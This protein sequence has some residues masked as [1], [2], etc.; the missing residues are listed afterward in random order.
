MQPYDE[1]LKA[2]DSIDYIAEKMRTKYAILPVHTPEEKDLFRRLLGANSNDRDFK[3]MAADWNMRYAN[4]KTV[5]YKL[6]CQLRR[7]YVTYRKIMNSVTTLQDSRPERSQ[8]S[9]EF[10]R[11]IV[12]HLPA[13]QIASDVVNQPDIPE[14]VNHD[15]DQ[16]D[17]TEQFEGTMHQNPTVQTATPMNDQNAAGPVINNTI[18]VSS[19]SGNVPVP[20][21]PNVVYIDPMTRIH[22]LNQIARH[23]NQPVQ[24]CTQPMRPPNQ[25]IRPPEQPE[26]PEVPSPGR[27]RRRCTTCGWGT[28]AGNGWRGVCRTPRELWLPYKRRPRKKRA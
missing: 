13:R 23:L 20:I 9:E 19:T 21:R 27:N 8:L 26:R 10:S 12:E 2:P 5:F 17:S 7:F 25:P 6:E 1:S 14:E 16:F 24:P 18:W 3:S 28:C 22:M 15:I 4:G 11:R